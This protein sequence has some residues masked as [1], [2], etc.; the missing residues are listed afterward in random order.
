MVG[1]P[2]AS[3]VRFG[4]GTSDEERKITASFV[5]DVDPT[6]DEGLKKEMFRPDEN[7]LVHS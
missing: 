1:K 7:I 6:H 5:R 2:A 3:K 4:V